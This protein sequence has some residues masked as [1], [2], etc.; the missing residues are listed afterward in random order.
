MSFQIAVDVTDTFLKKKPAYLVTAVY[1]D[2]KG[3]P[4]EQP[5]PVGQPVHFAFEITDQEITKAGGWIGPMGI[6]LSAVLREAGL[7]H[8]SP[9]TQAVRTIIDSKLPPKGEVH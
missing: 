2:T 7:I 4:G 1:F 8:D 6:A 9:D 5:T 3:T